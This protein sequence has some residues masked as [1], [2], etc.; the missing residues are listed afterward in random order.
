MGDEP[1]LTRLAE[2]SMTK[3]ARLAVDRADREIER[4]RGWLEYLAADCQGA[5]DALD[6]APVPLKCAPG[7]GD[8][9]QI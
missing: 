9:S 6:G 1:E 2:L 3:L 8:A 4:L 5:E 7:A